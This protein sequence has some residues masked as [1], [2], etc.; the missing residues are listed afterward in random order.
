[1]PNYQSIDRV[2]HALA[3][4]TR[5]AVL[6]RLSLGSASVSELAEPFEMA[7]PSFLQHLHVLQSCGL[8]NSEK[9]GRIRTYT[10]E[11]A[12]LAEALGWLEQRRQQWEQRLDRLDTYLLTLKEQP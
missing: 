4:P 10:L 6:A 9:Q 1:M 12:P 7:L 8:V 5:M 2:F 3:D 11:P